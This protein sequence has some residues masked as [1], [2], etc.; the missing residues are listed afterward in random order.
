MWPSNSDQPSWQCNLHVSLLEGATGFALAT[1]GRPAKVPVRAQA[2]EAL[3]KAP[4][5]VVYISQVCKGSGVSHVGEGG[6]EGNSVPSLPQVRPYP[7]Q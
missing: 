3:P 4:H 1:H 5:R 2:E 7:T 6:E